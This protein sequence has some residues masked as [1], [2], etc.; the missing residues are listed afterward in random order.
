VI[1]AQD[2]AD[3]QDSIPYEV[4]CGLGPRVRREYFGT[5]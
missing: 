3:W 2:V 4:L 5:R 1:T